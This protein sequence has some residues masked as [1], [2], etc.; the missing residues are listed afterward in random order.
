MSKAPPWYCYPIALALLPIAFWVVGATVE[1]FT[2]EECPP[3]Y[4]CTPTG[5]WNHPNCGCWERK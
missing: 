3:F 4:Q 1:H 2:D 5:D